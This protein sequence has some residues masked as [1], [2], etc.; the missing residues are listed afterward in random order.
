M[1]YRNRGTYRYR[2]SIQ[3]WRELRRWRRYGT[4]T[5]MEEVA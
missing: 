1:I 2:V 3:W 4:V 5:F